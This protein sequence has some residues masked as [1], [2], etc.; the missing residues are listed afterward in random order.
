MIRIH[1][2]EDGNGRSSRA[3]LN[4]ILVRQD[5]VPIAVDALKDEYIAALNHYL[6]AGQIQPLLDLFIRLA[7]DQQDELRSQTEA[8]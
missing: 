1:P 6:R 4:A 8:P 2:F 7:S 5:L 3:L